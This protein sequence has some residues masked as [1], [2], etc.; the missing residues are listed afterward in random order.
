MTIAESRELLGNPQIH[1]EPAAALFG[2][3]GSGLHQHVVDEIEVRRKTV[4]TD[5]ARGAVQGDTV[6]VTGVTLG[7]Q[8]KPGGIV[9]EP[10]RRVIKDAGETMLNVVVGR[11]QHLFLRVVEGAVDV[12]REGHR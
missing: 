4:G 3:A 12:I 6:G 11:R 1:L 8:S 2:V 7:E 9:T 5:R 10:F